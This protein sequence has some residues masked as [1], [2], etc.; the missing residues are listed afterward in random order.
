MLRVLICTVALGV[1]A[2]ASV[3]P[4]VSSPTPEEAAILAVVDRFM[5]SVTNSDLA[6]LEQL[7]LAEGMTFVERPADGG[8]THIVARPNSYW[9]DPANLNRKQHREAYWNPTVLVRGSIAIVWTP[10]E[11]WIDGKTS[12][13]GIDAFDMVKVDGHWRIANSMWTVEREAC[14]ELRPADA[15]AIRPRR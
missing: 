12:H 6:L 2:S 10:Y 11:F 7:Q 13:C 5:D 8:G 1:S 14:T 15:S 3:S 9:I 4:A